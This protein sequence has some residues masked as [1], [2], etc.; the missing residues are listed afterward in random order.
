MYS[1]MCWDTYNHRLTFD[2]AFRL[3]WGSGS[4]DSSAPD[5]SISRNTAGV[6]AFGAGGTD[7]NGTI[8]A[9]TNAGAPTTANVPASTWALIRDTT[10]NTTKIY[11]NNAGTLMSVALT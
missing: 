5:T 10:N 9:M 3:A 11:Y 6:I 2:T 4:A 8:L 1:G 7:S